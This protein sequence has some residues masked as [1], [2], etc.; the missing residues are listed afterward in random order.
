MSRRFLLV[1]CVALSL[2]GCSAGAV[3]SVPATPT[4]A[5]VVAPTPTPIVIYVTPAPVPTTMPEATDTPVA[6]TPAPVADG[7]YQAALGERV[8]I[9]C[10]GSDCLDIAVT[11]ASFAKYYRDPAGFLNDTP[12]KGDVYLQFYV[13]YKATG[14]DATYNEFDWTV[15]VADTAVNNSSFTMHGPSPELQSGDLAVGKS[16]AGWVV[17]EVPAVGRVVIAYQP[18]YTGNDIFEVVARSK[19]AAVLL[20][21]LGTTAY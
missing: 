4:T 3:E 16:A 19:S 13:T 10:D 14:S 5:A 12:K 18:G 2:A 7:P 21:E 9:T 1:A 15:Y 11:K 17:Q 20:C 8:S 6:D